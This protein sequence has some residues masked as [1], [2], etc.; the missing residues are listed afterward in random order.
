MNANDTQ[1]A[2]FMVLFFKNP[3]CIL[4]TQDM[5]TL[6]SV[7]GNVGITFTSEIFV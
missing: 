2:A 4:T 7:T 1:T 6:F 3:L 5:C